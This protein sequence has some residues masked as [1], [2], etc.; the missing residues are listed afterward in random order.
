[1]REKSLMPVNILNLPSYM[2]LRLKTIS[3]DYYIGAETTE[4]TL[5]VFTAP[6]G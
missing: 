3:G 4:P 2:V 5:T 6:P 1:M